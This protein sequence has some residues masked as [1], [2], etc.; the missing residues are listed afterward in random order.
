[1]RE[2]YSYN[3][4][5]NYPNPFNPSTTISYSLKED[6]IVELKVYDILGREVKTLV[7]ESETKGNHT[8]TFDASDLASGVYLHKLKVNDYVAVKKMLLVN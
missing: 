6:G 4:L 8:I 1:M 5:Q 7:N 2:V 3:L